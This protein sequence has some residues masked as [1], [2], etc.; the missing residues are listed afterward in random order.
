MQEWKKVIK[1]VMTKVTSDFS[2][3]FEVMT[4]IT[5]DFSHYFCLWKFF[6]SNHFY[7]VVLALVYH[8]K[9]FVSSWQWIISLVVEVITCKCNEI[10]HSWPLATHDKFHYFYSWL[11]QPL[12]ILSNTF[13]H[14][15]GNLPFRLETDGEDRS[16]KSVYFT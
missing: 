16:D 3:Y 7:L 8:F 10:Y 4:K 11:P 12:V 9:L 1:K 6:K 14:L 13:C 5:S 15:H 2:H